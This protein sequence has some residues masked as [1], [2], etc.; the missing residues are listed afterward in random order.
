MQ[1]LLAAGQLSL[2]VIA[3]IFL[4]ILCVREHRHTLG[5]ILLGLAI[6]LKPQLAGPF[7]LWFLLFSRWRALGVA[8]AIPVLLN[9]AAVARMELHG[10]QWF[11]DWSHELAMSFAPGGPGDPAATGPWT[12]QMIDL[13]VWLFTLFDQR[14]LV[15][16]K[17]VVIAALLAAIYLVVLMRM[18][19]ERS[20]LL[21]LAALCALTLLPVYHRA[22]DAVLLLPA[23]SWAL[24]VV[25]RPRRTIALL[26]LAA[27]SI[28][29]VP[30]DFLPLV[31]ERTRALDGLAKTWIWRVVIYPHYAVATLATALCM[32]WAMAVNV[33]VRDRRE[34]PAAA[35]PVGRLHDLASTRG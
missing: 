18:R 32:V 33:R 30:W 27:L 29:L 11:Y 25:R 1:T 10:H 15:A 2:P 7:L 31:M 13:R 8:C 4:S 20:K 5:A 28:F 21:P 3:L 24:L 6:T 22:Y 19:H 17:V 34:Q 12:N 26:T 14:E 23:L 9:L 16:I 35:E